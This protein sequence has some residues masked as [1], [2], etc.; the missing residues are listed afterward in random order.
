MFTSLIFYFQFFLCFVA[1]PSF[2]HVIPLHGLGP[3]SAP[4]KKVEKEISEHYLFRFTLS[5]DI[6]L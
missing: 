2:I 4:I 6:C 3:Y 5:S 1:D